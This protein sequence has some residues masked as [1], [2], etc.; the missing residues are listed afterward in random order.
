MTAASP[1]VV[2]LFLDNQHY[3]SDEAYL[4]ALAEAM[5]AEYDEIHRAGFVLQLDCPD[6]AAGRHRDGESLEDFRGRVALHLEALDHAT[7]DVPESDLRLHLCWG[8][9]EGPHTR[10]VPLAD[11]LDLVLAAPLP[12]CRSRRPT[13]GTPTNGRSSPTSACRR[14]RC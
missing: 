9:Y 12:A 3:P 5:K 14:A 11:I 2:A 1:G 8:N 10:D 13:H 4:F 7:R 6:L